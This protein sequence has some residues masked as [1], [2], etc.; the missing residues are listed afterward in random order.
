MSN[1]EALAHLLAELR[2]LLADFAAHGG[3]IAIYN[4]SNSTVQIGDNNVAKNQ[5]RSGHQVTVGGSVGGHITVEADIRNS[6][7]GHIGSIPEP[8]ELQKQLD[9]LSKALI[10][11]TKH[12]QEASAKEAAE[13]YDSLA[14]EAAKVKPRPKTLKHHLD[15]LLDKAKTLGAIAQPVVAVIQSIMALVSA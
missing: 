5:E 11:M 7:T 13:D 3:S 6:F 10:D 2:A 9:E 1:P 14:K 8:S 12:L 4:I 15:Q